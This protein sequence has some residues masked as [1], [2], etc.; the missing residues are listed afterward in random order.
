MQQLDLRLRNLVVRDRMKVD[1]RS[2][3]GGWRVV[4][5][6]VRLPPVIGYRFKAFAILLHRNSCLFEEDFLVHSEIGRGLVFRLWIVRLGFHWVVWSS[7]F[8]DEIF[9]LWSLREVRHWVGGVTSNTSECRQ[10]DVLAAG[11]RWYN[12][13]VLIQA[14]PPLASLVVQWGYESR[15]SVCWSD[16][17]S[18]KLWA[19][20]F[21]PGHYQCPRTRSML[22]E[23]SWHR[24]SSRS[25]CHLRIRL[26]AGRVGTEE[27][28]LAEV[29]ARHSVAQ[30][31]WFTYRIEQ[32]F[33]WRTFA[34]A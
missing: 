8:S 11:L 31:L 6:L 7:F 25:D 33:L 14:V 4:T 32:N 12:L 30:R 3:D 9:V 22:I 10:V 24:R 27:R 1:P 2:S 5:M 17:I 19:A 16:L 29:A 34:F 13:L 20:R 23:L 28:K 15:F 18:N 26:V 21:E